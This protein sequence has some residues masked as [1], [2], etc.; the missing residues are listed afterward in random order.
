MTYSF[1]KVGS[2]INADRELLEFLNKLPETTRIVSVEAGRFGK[3][4]G[5]DE[6]YERG[7]K[8]LLKE[9]SE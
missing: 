7:Y 9:K 3:W 2:G 8:V 5:L 6:E 4:H 1:V